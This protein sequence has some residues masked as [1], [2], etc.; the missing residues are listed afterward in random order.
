MNTLLEHNSNELPWRQVP[1]A[2][3][4]RLPVDKEGFIDLQEME[5]QLRAYNVENR[6][7]NRRIQLVTVSGASNILGTY[8]DLAQIGQLVHRY[9][10]RLLVDAAQMVAHRK[11][12]MDAWGDR[13]PGVLRPQGLR[14]LW[15][16]RAV[17]EAWSAA[18]FA[19]RGGIN[20]GIRGGERG[21]YRP[22]WGKALVI[23]QRIGTDV[24]QA[25]ETALTRRA[26]E[27]MTDIPGVKVHGVSDPNSPRFARR[28]GVIAFSL[29][30]MM[31]DRIA[32]E[33]AARGGIGVRYGCHC[34]HLLG[35]KYLL[36]VSP[37]LA[38]FQRVMLT[39]LRKVALPG[40]GAG[41]PRD[42]EQRRGRGYV[43]PRPGSDCQATYAGA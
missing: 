1:G 4:V 21:G 15:L 28:G 34:A 37:G 20:P 42:R 11:V 25:E 5:A 23:L 31:S 29:D 24:I 12:E 22:R 36:D 41:E 40:G 3:L 17:G 19:G 27:Q 16:R 26:L 30:K 13:L 38:R 10:A 43:H 35:V 9:G 6:Y 8:N 32:K 7:G 14:A 18:I 33:L 2:T 39:L